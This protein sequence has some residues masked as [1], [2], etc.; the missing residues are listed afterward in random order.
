MVTTNALKTSSMKL[1]DLESKSQYQATQ[2]LGNPDTAAAGDAKDLRQS[3]H[4]TTTTFVSLGDGSVYQHNPY[5]R[6]VEGFADTLCD[7]EEE[8]TE[9]QITCAFLEALQEQHSYYKK[10]EA[11][12]SNLHTTLKFKLNEK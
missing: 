3:M 11:F 10:K 6:A 8:L 1:N 2:R 12:Y 7:A 9:E 4:D 5:I